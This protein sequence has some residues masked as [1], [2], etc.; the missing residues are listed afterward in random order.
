MKNLSF[1]DYLTLLQLVDRHVKFL[2]QDPKR[3][4]K[5][6]PMFE[7]LRVTLAKCLADASLKDMD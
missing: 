1:K 5:S 4:E 3:N 7:S 2:E 6:L